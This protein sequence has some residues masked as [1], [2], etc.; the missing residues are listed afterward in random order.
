MGISIT[1]L[2]ENTANFGYLGEWGLSVFLEIDGV[3][4]LFDTGLGV[5]AAHNAHLLGIDLMSVAKIVLS[6]GHSDHTGG[7]R[8]ILREKGA[9]DIIAH[10]DIWEAKYYGL[11]EINRFIGIPFQREELEL[12][13]ASFNLTRDPVWITDSVFTA[14]EIPMVTD[15]EEI[16]PDLAVRKGNRLVPD[17]LAD[18]LAVAVK[19]ETGLIVILGCGH[20]GL[21][22]TLKHARN[23]TGEKRI[24]VVIGGIHLFLASEERL[25]MTCADLREMGIERLGV[26]HCTGFKASAWLAQEF[27]DIFFL[28]NAGT[29]LS[30]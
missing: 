25:A 9:V 19:T 3:N 4:I 6:H 24:K 22:N 18:D 5:S 23:L 30:F 11:G 20:R 26:S 12:L 28:N 14:G 13:G 17:P 27:G 10:P 7:L 15:Y 2:T 8:D 1:T 21:V 29:R 16:D